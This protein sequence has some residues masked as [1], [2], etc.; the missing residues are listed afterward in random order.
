MS[1]RLPSVITAIKYDLL[2]G[3][4]SSPLTAIVEI[5]PVGAGLVKIAGVETEFFLTI[6]DSG[7]LRA[8]VSKHRSVSWFARIPC[9]DASRSGLP[10]SPFPKSNLGLKKRVCAACNQPQDLRVSSSYI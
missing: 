10:K 9:A 4:F 3:V 2:T 1:N 5:C 8:T 7:I 6:D